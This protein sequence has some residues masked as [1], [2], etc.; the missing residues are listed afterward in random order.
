MSAAAEHARRQG[1][2]RL[3]RNAHERAR[4][5][6]LTIQFTEG[7]GGQSD[8]SVTEA[9]DDACDAAIQWL[10]SFSRDS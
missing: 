4:Q 2:A 9:F 1:L 5:L 6:R 8:P 3:A 7:M 10:E